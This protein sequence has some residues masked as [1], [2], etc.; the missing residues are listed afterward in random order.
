MSPSADTSLILPVRIECGAPN[1]RT[2]LLPREIK[3]Y[4]CISHASTTNMHFHSSIFPFLTY[5]AGELRRKMEKPPHLPR[6]V[7]LKLPFIQYEQATML[8]KVMG[9]PASRLRQTKGLLGGPDLEYNLAPPVKDLGQLER[10]LSSAF[11]PPC[12]GTTSRTKNGTI[13]TLIPSLEF[14]LSSKNSMHAPMRATFK[15]FSV[16]LTTGGEWLWPEGVLFE[17]EARLVVQNQVC[18][19]VLFMQRFTTSVP[20]TQAVQMQC[21]HH[22]P[23]GTHPVGY[24]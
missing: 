5:L 7:V 16:A 2:T 22:C 12:A 18:S 11:K 17:P 8:C 23:P 14:K 20:F 19:N 15:L 24:P 3:C 21:A 4:S 1:C 9:I 13:F 6:A 10:L